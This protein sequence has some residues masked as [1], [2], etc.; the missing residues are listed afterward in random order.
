MKTFAFF[1]FKRNFQDENMFCS[2]K[3]LSQVT[4]E[5]DFWKKTFLCVTTFTPMTHVDF[6]CGL[7]L[8]NLLQQQKS[9]RNHAKV[10]LQQ[11]VQQT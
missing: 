8:H 11:N 5:S 1:S 9:V 3:F 6:C 2:W 10:Q 7:L 4:F